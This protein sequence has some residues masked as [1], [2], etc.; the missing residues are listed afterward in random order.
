MIESSRR[1]FLFGLGASL[2]AAPA[3]VRA[4]SLMPV[5]S[6][7]VLPSF[8]WE[9][10]T[11]PEGMVYQWVTRRVMGEVVPWYE[12]SMADG[13]WTPVDAARYKK[14]FAIGGGEVE[15][16]G[17]VL[18]E[19]PTMEPY[20]HPRPGRLDEFKGVVAGVNET[21][22]RIGNQPGRYQASG[23]LIMPQV[24]DTAVTKESYTMSFESFEGSKK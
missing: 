22:R 21:W 13:G 6:M 17:Q 3:I 23:P 7:L 5:R 10:F 12:E 2:F 18:M 24:R 15:F 20:L 9:S 8:G 19:R 4:A 14:Q 1:G 11:P 16:G